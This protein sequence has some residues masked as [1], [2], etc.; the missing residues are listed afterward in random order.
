M[1][2]AASEIKAASHDANESNITDTAV[3]SDGTWQRRGYSSLN[4]A[5]VA[6][7]METGRVLDVENYES[8]LQSMCRK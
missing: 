6:I 4:G 7:S 2:F 1:T 8:L 5:V 3:S